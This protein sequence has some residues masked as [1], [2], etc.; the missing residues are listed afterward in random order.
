MKSLGVTL[1]YRRSSRKCRGRSVDHVERQ[2]YI[3]C[4]REYNER[5]QKRFDGEESCRIRIYAFWLCYVDIREWQIKRK[6][7]IGICMQV[8]VFE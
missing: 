5:S 3:R 8:V 1:M 7:M 2:S 4:R 6:K